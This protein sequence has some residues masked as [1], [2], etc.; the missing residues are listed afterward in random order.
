MIKMRIIFTISQIMV[1]L[2]RKTNNES[3]TV[4]DICKFGYRNKD[5][6]REWRGFN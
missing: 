4:Q 2:Y 5:G 1:E 3:I 6:S